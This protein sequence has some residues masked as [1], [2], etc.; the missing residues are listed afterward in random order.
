MRT[1]D[2]IDSL[3]AR[4]QRVS[5]HA[6]EQRIVAG[7]LLGGGAT[8]AVMAA[9]L[10]FR[11][12]LGH[13]MMTEPFLVKWAYTLSLSIIAVLA[14]IDAARP[15]TTR[16]RRLWMVAVPVLLLA[17]AAGAELANA[18]A[19][20]WSS[21]VMGY[22][23][24]QCSMRVGLFALPIFVGL[25]W[26][27]RRL[28]PTRLVSAGAAAGLAAGAFGA[29]LYGLH[30]SEVSMVFVLTWYSLGIAVSAGVGALIGP[31]VLR[32]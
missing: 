24:R 11:P 21:M 7:L 26:A 22:S 32:W 29:T 9:T 31:R 17:I 8:L 3:T 28:A 5:R 16:L 27:F 23:W 10:G 19:S 30:C 13:A 1:E 2:L 25:L 6:T 15:E 20:H 18:P 14:V 12:D 4:T